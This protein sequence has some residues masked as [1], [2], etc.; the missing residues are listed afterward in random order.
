[1]YKQTFE[2]TT[3]PL[4]LKSKKLLSHETLMEVF[5]FIQFVKYDFNQDIHNSSAY[6]FNVSPIRTPTLSNDKFT[7][8]L[9]RNLEIAE[10][11][12]N[13]FN[14][15]YTLE[16]LTG[17]IDPVE[18]IETTGYAFVKLREILFNTK[19]LFEAFALDTIYSILKLAGVTDFMLESKHF[20]M[21]SG[22]VRWPIKYQVEDKV[23]HK[24]Y[25]SS[26]TI[27]FHYVE[28]EIPDVPS[29]YNVD[30][31]GLVD[32]NLIVFETISAIDGKAFGAL[33]EGFYTKKHFQ[34]FAFDKRMNLIMYDTKNKS[35]QFKFSTTSY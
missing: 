9:R 6:L 21:A 34:D 20:R 14:P 4:V 17:D 1:M 10:A 29:A 33:T 2:F 32:P 8:Y 28:E 25:I 31:A 16:N 30:T 5:E 24:T 12:G 7:Y 11:T 35:H 15:F 23:F 27:Y 13:Y 3:Y 22:R 18:N 19:P 26:G